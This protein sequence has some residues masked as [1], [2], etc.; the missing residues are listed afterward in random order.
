MTTNK[1]IKKVT[2]L[3][4]F[5]FGFGLSLL[6]QSSTNEKQKLNYKNRIFISPANFCDPINPSL[7]IGYERS[8]SNR[9][10]LQ[11]EYGYITGRSFTGY[12]FVDLLGFN[13]TYWY[14]FSGYKLR[15]ELKR[16]FK[17]EPN[18][19]VKRYFSVEIFYNDTYSNVNNLFL[20]SDTTYQYEEEIPQGANAY[21][22]FFDVDKKKIGINIKYGFL[23]HLNSHF[24]IENYIG[25][26]VAYRNSKHIGRENLND[27][28]YD[29]L[30]SYPNKEGHSWMISLPLNFKIGYRF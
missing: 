1:L 20:I 22:D 10:A 11:L 7:Q 27:K 2:F 25:L 28:F 8:L 14:T 24:H 18:P 13:E 6:A 12:M 17:V 4:F 23:I 15:G 19:S 9:Y 26:G 5:L 16:Y 30:F 3:L 29:T 21:D